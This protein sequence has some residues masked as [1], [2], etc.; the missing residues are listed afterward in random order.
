[1]VCTVRAL[2]GMACVDIAHGLGRNRDAVTHWYKKYEAE[3]SLEGRPQSGRR[4]ATSTTWTRPWFGW[5]RLRRIQLTQLCCLGSSENKAGIP[6]D[7]PCPAGFRRMN[8][9]GS[10]NSPNLA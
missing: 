10:P 1:M 3:V 2:R 7:G 6:A 8:F 5:P 4:H 9:S